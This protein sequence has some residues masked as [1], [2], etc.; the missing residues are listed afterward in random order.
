MFVCSVPF[1]FSPAGIIRRVTS[2]FLVLSVILSVMLL[3]NLSDIRSTWELLSQTGLIGIQ[4]YLY[5]LARSS[6]LIKGKLSV[7]IIVPFIA[8]ACSVGA[9]NIFG[10]SLTIAWWS[11]FIALLLALLG[12]LFGFR[13]KQII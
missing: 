4:L 12:L 6:Q 1:A 5:Q 11:L 7:L 8:S 9:A 3:T 13:K 2:V 10:T